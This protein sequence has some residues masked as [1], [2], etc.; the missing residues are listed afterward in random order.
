MGKVFEK[1]HESLD[2][3]VE[4]IKEW[5][6]VAVLL[7]SMV[8]GESVILTASFLAH[9]GY[10][11]I[12]KIM[13]IA[14]LGTLFADQ[15]LYQVGYHYGPR[16]FDRFPSAKNRTQRAFDLLHKWDSWFIL[17]CRFIYGIRIISP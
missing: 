9:E 2:Y 16:F 14:F 8:E 3:F 7:G 17:S 13:G 4:F 5:G 11:S 15:A 12:T 1:L 6:Y 10:F